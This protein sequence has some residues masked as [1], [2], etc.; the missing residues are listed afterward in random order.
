MLNLSGLG[1]N[2]GSEMKK[3]KICIPFPREG[4]H[5][6]ILYPAMWHLSD[7]MSHISNFG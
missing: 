6:V 2:L 3:D 5:A 1:S 7:T 4:T